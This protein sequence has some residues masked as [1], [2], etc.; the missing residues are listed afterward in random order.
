MNDQEKLTLPQTYEP[1][2]GPAHGDTRSELLLLSLQIAVPLKIAEIRAK[3]GPNDFQWEWARDFADEL[4]ERGDVLQF[5]GQRKGETATIFSRFAFALAIMAF[6][7]GG[8]KFAG[9]H[10]EAT[11]ERGS[12]DDQR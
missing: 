11:V 6:V 9:L 4:G 1:I 10:F 2:R 7:P 12:R 3:G 5:K 8:V